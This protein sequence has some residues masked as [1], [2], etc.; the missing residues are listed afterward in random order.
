MFTARDPSR[1]VPCS[2]R[3]C[4]LLDPDYLWCSWEPSLPLLGCSLHSL[5]PSR[6]SA[7]LWLNP[8]LALC[9]WLGQQHPHLLLRACSFV[10]AIESPYG[11]CCSC[12]VIAEIKA[13]NSTHAP[14]V[15]DTPF[16]PSY[17]SLPNAP[18]VHPH[19]LLHLRC[20]SARFL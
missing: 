19:S 4:G 10:C 13:T 17:L 1:F 12:T 11:L 6:L 20:S 18:F 14:R 15:A 5:E 7:P 3:A 16:S 8:S 2:F 9:F